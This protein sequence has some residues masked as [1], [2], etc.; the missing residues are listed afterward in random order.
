MDGIWSFQDCTFVGVVALV[1]G[2]C[3]WYIRDVAMAAVALACA[4]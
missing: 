2:C 4:N 1:G 3:S